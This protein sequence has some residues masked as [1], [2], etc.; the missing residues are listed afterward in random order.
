MPVLQHGTVTF[1]ALS[2]PD[3]IAYTRESGEARIIVVADMSEK[4]VSSVAPTGFVGVGEPLLWTVSPRDLICQQME[5]APY[6][7]VAVLCTTSG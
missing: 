2:H 6:E 4:P 5:F 1:V 7:A 3:V